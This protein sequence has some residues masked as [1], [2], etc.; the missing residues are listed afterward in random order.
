MS[1]KKKEVDPNREAI[2]AFLGSPFKSAIEVFL[3]RVSRTG[4]ID[5]SFC[6]VMSICLYR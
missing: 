2:K 4:T 3:A 6:G 5:Q 1:S